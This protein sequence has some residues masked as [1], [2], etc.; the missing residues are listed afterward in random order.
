MI[1]ENPI[2]SGSIQI[3]GSLN[4]NGGSI[5][6]SPATASHALTSLS[7]SYVHGNNIDGT[8][9]SAITS[10]VITETRVNN[11]LSFWQGTQAQYDVLG[12]YSST[13]LYIV[14]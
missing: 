3:S 2:L 14:T 5:G 8:V 10:S 1:Y 12:S 6:I 13:T 11:Q 7:S 9:V 4:L